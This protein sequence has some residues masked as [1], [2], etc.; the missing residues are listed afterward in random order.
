MS[1]EIRSLQRSEIN[2]AYIN[3]Q[4]KPVKKKEFSML[5]ASFNSVAGFEH[6]SETTK[7]NNDVLGHKN[8]IK[9]WEYLECEFYAMENKGVWN[10]VPISSM[11]H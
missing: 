7:N 11:P 3:R 5:Y 1:Q 9:W 6:G 2:V 10:I 8:Q 4:I